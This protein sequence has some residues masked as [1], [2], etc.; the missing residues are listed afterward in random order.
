MQTQQQFLAFQPS[1]WGW[2]H[3]TCPTYSEPSK[4]LKNSWLSDSQAFVGL[5]SL[6]PCEPIYLIFLIIAQVYSI[7]WIPLKTPKLNAYVQWMPLNIYGSLSWPPFYRSV[8]DAYK[9]FWVIWFLWNHCYTFLLVD[10]FAWWLKALKVCWSQTGPLLFLHPWEC[11][12]QFLWWLS[13]KKML[14]FN[15]ISI[16]LFVVELPLD[17]K[18]FHEEIRMIFSS[19]LSLFSLIYNSVCIESRWAALRIQCSVVNIWPPYLTSWVCSQSLFSKWMINL[20]SGSVS[21]SFLR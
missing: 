9:W 8:Q 5:S 16:F 2:S 12:L 18:S 15:E 19:V 11:H 6:W 17:K 13:I 14:H 4:F 7:G 3:I 21:L 1:A 20:R 10:C